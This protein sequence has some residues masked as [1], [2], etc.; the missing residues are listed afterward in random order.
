MGEEHIIEDLQFLYGKTWQFDVINVTSGKQIRFFMD[1]EELSEL[2][3]E[4]R[5]KA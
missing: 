4:A 5:G 1:D 3:Q 2:M